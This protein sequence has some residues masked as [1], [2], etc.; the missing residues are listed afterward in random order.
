MFEAIMQIVSG[1]VILVLLV[2]VCLYGMSIVFPG[3]SVAME[4]AVVILFAA[5][6]MMWHLTDPDYS[7]GQAFLW[8]VV[9]VVVGIVA[10]AAVGLSS[11]GIR[12]VAVP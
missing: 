10:L 8:L 2:A 3:N 6:M 7:A 4:G 12:F 11:G 5:G 1:V 9:F